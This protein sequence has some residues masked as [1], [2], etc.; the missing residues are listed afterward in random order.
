M[1]PQDRGSALALALLRASLIPVILVSERLVDARRLAG[2][3]FF[4]VLIIASVYAL[5]AV[6]NAWNFDEAAWRLTFARAQ[7][8]LDVLFLA[9]LTLT[10]GGAFSDARKAFFVIPLA[11]AFSER[12]RSTAKWSLV[13]VAAFTLQATLSGGHPAGAQNSW[14]RVTI[15]QDLYLAWAGA[16]ATLLAVGLGRRSA[17]TAVL[18]RDRGRLVTLAME[19]VER[20]RSRLASA[21]HDS[22]VQN[23]IAARH[24]LRR[25]QRRHDADSFDRL[26]E[27]ID[28][29]VEQ[30]REEIFRLHPH[31]LDHVGLAA[32][33]EQVVRRQR[34]DPGTTVTLEVD[35]GA[36]DTHR[37]ILF[38]LARELL[39][40][41]VKH[42]GAHAIQL[43]VAAGDDHVALVVRDDGSGIAAGRIEEAL[44][45]GHIGLASVR[46]RVLALG[47]GLGIET[48]LG[49]GTTVHITLP[50]Q[51]R[52]AA[53]AMG[54]CDRVTRLDA[55]QTSPA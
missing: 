54:V 34:T 48:A 20:E 1:S 53:G 3:A 8:G 5:I 23:L 46:E 26:H 49:D 36:D 14:Q 24:D 10:S 40:N 44:M 28:S 9:G 51:R 47:G 52:H 45:Q 12:A 6:V 39:A 18:A 11:A 31:V 55:R 32:A 25:A 37:N 29:T 17:Y 42:A 33:L 43:R 22:P 16:A 4:I 7:P 41:A 50:A 38:A 21:L 35:P 2:S 19:A 15:N 27:A 30:L 13:A